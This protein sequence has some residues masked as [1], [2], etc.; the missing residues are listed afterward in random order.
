MKYALIFMFLI[1][2][3]SVNAAEEPA[4]VL[5][6]VEPDMAHEYIPDLKT[7]PY[8]EATWEGTLTIPGMGSKKIAYT[9]L[10][11]DKNA[12]ELY[13]NASSFGVTI[14]HPQEPNILFVMTLVTKSPDEVT[15]AHEAVH[16]Y[17]VSWLSEMGIDMFSIYNNPINEMSFYWD[18]QQWSFDQLMEAIAVVSS[19]HAAHGMDQEA[20][21][22]R[23]CRFENDE[24]FKLVRYIVAKTKCDRAEMQRESTKML[25][26]FMQ[27]AP[28]L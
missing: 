5:F 22:N 27:T 2:M 1:M 21:T 26:A 3:S 6:I 20:L 13:P 17:L 25:E 11:F 16:G 14:I 28:K 7:T 10:E 18:E 15:L 19:M 23:V 8:H 9:Y 24:L 12:D 4:R